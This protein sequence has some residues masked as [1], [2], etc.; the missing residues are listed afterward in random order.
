MYTLLTHKRGKGQKFTLVGV[1]DVETQEK[2]P[3]EIVA[4][5]EERKGKAMNQ[6]NKGESRILIYVCTLLH[7]KKRIRVLK[8]EQARYHTNGI[9]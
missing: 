4:A 7:K 8:Y 1:H 3:C 2:S 5:E 6:S 9:E